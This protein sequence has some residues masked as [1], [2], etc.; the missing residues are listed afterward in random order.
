MS[1]GPVFGRKEEENQDAKGRPVTSAFS[2]T[3]TPVDTVSACVAFY[4]RVMPCLVYLISDQDREAVNEC[5]S[6]SF[7]DRNRLDLAFVMRGGI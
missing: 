3:G 2:P 4:R 1:V 6:L 7:S 5:T